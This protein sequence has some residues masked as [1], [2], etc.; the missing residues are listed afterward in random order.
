LTENGHLWWLD[1]IIMSLRRFQARDRGITSLPRG[2]REGRNTPYPSLEID[3][4]YH[5][6]SKTALNEWLRKGKRT[7]PY[8]FAEK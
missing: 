4:M 3:V 6:V 5:Y 7:P 8:S 1:H 2:S